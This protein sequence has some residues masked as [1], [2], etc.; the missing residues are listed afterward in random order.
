MVDFYG[1][2]CDGFQ[3][4]DGELC[5]KFGS[6]LYVKI[7]EA[8]WSSGNKYVFDDYSL[9]DYSIEKGAWGNTWYL[10]RGYQEVCSLEHLGGLNFKTK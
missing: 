5:D 3:I 7:R 9:M 8:Q 2:I 4:K 6:H 1:L 10:K